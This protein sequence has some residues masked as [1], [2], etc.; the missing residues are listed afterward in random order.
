MKLKPFSNGGAS[1]DDDE[2]DEEEEWEKE[3]KNGTDRVADNNTDSADADE[4][5]VTKDTIFIFF[6][7][8]PFP[9]IYITQSNTFFY[10]LI[11]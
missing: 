9:I 7:D 2:D 10:S 5:S 3:D 1:N 8:Y 11:F 6:V 4:S